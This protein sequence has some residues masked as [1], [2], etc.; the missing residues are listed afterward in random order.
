MLA[1]KLRIKPVIF[2][3]GNVAGRIQALQQHR[4][5]ENS[6]VSLALFITEA[7]RLANVFGPFARAFGPMDE[8]SD[9][10]ADLL[11]P[12]VELRNGRIVNPPLLSSL[13]H[14]QNGP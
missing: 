11:N 4:V 7:Q 2:V 9:G 14:P 13:S 1:I 10:L 3:R 8:R 6:N 12:T 5:A